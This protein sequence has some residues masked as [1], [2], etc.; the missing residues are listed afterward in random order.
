MSC[1]LLIYKE[2]DHLKTYEIKIHTYIFL[3]EIGIPFGI[4]V[5]FDSKKS[6]HSA[7]L[8]ERDTMEQ[9][10]I[11]ID[12]IPQVVKSLA[13][14]KLTWNEVQLKYPKFEQQEN[15]K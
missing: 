6:P 14:D 11:P 15:A 7:T 8:R 3:D 10:R 2:D 12:E 1:P 5:D 4:C 9:V 13:N